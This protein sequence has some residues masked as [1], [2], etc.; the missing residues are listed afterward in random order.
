MVGAAKCPLA[1]VC[2]VP[3]IALFAVVLLYVNEKRHAEE[4]TAD[5]QH[6]HD[7]VKVV[8]LAL[9]QVLGRQFVRPD[10][11]YGPKTRAAIEHF[12]N[13]FGMPLGGDVA[14]QLKIVSMTLRE[15]AKAQATGMATGD[16]QRAAGTQ[17]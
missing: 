5:A 2:L 8:Q 15:A 13:E 1:L 6:W 12:Q 10:G 17:Q 3:T 4:A 14:E 7:E 11:V 16:E 9:N